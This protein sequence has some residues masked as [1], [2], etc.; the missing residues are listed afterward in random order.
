MLLCQII[1]SLPRHDKGEMEAQGREGKGKT[2]SKIIQQIS[3]DI[4]TWHVSLQ[5]G[6][7]QWLPCLS[8]WQEELSQL[9][10]ALPSVPMCVD[11]AY[12]LCLYLN[13]K[14]NKSSKWQLG[15]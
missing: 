3:T 12:L 10:T 13:I 11:G 7:H 1:D 4:M 15:E 2:A 8:V 6:P 9:S 5:L 14:E